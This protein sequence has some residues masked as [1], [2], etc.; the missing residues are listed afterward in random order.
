MLF[1]IK[2]KMALSKTYIRMFYFFLIFLGQYYLMT[3]LTMIYSVREYLSYYSTNDIRLLGQ[4]HK[5]RIDMDLV[6]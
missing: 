2:R 1:M 5:Q 4:L 6:S 3:F